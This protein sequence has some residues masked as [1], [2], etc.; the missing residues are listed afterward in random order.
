M[1]GHNGLNVFVEST[2]VTARMEYND[3]VVLGNAITAF[4]QVYIMPG[5]EFEYLEAGKVI[6]KGHVKMQYE[7]SANVRGSIRQE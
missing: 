6:G 3:L 5:V 4:Q 7:S 1:C 2:Q